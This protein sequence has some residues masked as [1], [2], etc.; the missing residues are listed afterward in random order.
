[1]TKRCTYC[2]KKLDLGEDLVAAQHGV[3]GPRGFVPLDDYLLLCSEAC[4]ARY[5]EDT[6]TAPPRIP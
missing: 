3:L 6:P 4:I 1:M 5:F 2:R